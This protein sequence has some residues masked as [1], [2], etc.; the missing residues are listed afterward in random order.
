MVY[1]IHVWSCTWQREQ[2]SIHWAAEWNWIQEKK[3]RSVM[4]LLQ[5]LTMIDAQRTKRRRKNAIRSSPLSYSP[6]RQNECTNGNFWLN[7]RNSNNLS[8]FHI[9]QR[10]NLHYFIEMIF[11]FD[12]QANFS[13]I[14]DFAFHV[15]VDIT[16]T[17]YVYAIG[18]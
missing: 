4:I 14:F 16:Y 13:Y 6:K 11:K 5:R 1:V 3:Q 7:L 10:M 15:C 17:L 18:V 12:E 2:P 9:K 8:Y